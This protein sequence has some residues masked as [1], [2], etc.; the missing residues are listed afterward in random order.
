MSD[1]TL[2]LLVAI[3]SSTALSSLIQFIITFIFNRKDKTKEME[4]EIKELRC[5]ITS[6][7]EENARDR[8]ISARVRIQRFA[9]EI[10]NGIK[11]SEESFRQQVL[12]CDTY[13]R[14]CDKHDDF[15]NGLTIVASELI[16]REYRNL[17]MKGGNQDETA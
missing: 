6:L 7:R 14:F 3:I 12:E 13:D 4:N 9:D 15:S 10:R 8:A 16:R 1:Q 17:M 11:H 5:E 2:T